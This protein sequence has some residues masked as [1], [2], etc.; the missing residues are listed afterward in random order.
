MRR[1]AAQ[2]HIALPGPVVFNHTPNWI[3]DD[4]S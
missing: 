1:P 4:N 2:T 3:L